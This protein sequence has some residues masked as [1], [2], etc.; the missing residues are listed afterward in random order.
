MTPRIY[1]LA[2]AL[3]AGVVV[4]AHLAAQGTLS[5]Q[6]FGYPTG[7]LSIRARGT[8]GGLGQFDP[9]SPL[10]PAAIGTSSDPRMFLQ[11][12]PEYRRLARGDQ[13]SNT[14]TAR[15]SLAAASVPFAS[16]GS[17][18]L[19]VATFLDR[20]SFTQITTQQAIAGQT[21]TVDEITQVLG[22]INDVRL[23]FGYAPSSKI[24][25]GAG[26][27]VFVG[28]NRMFFT[29]SF[30]GESS[31]ASLTQVSTLAFTGFAASAGI[32]AR[33][34]RHIGL[35]L[36]ARKGF[37]IEARAGDSVVSEA[38]IPDRF[39]AALTYEGIPGTSVS[40]HVA[41]DLWSAMNG[42]GSSKATA[43]DG[44]EGGL[45]LEALGP[46]IA[47][48]QTILRLGGRYRT[49]PFLAAGSE[50]NE[51]SFGGGIGAQFFR[52]RATFDISF[53]RASRTPELSSVDVTE[54][55]YI[56]GFGLRV[57]P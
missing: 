6:G 29:Q 51:L 34:S 53:E 10:N 14:L 54:R 33:P 20:S 7:E 36:S 25:F 5:T 4:P 48:R 55:A 46:R 26:G 23:A 28:Q 1:F 44:W 8:G 56:F 24:Q 47:A 2:A 42:L 27:H 11:Y 19:S 52:N 16:R 32:L 50:V 43:V 18:G 17:I 39:S 57:R 21:V 22:A 38:N 13:T 49:L 41:R 31:F 40:A 12:E 3:A 9:D 37:S 45:G 15:F 30:P 35:A